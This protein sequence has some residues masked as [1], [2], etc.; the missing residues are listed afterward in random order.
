MGALACSPSS[1]LQPSSFPA[2]PVGWQRPRPLRARTPL[3]AGGRTPCPAAVLCPR[4]PLLLLPLH[5]L[6]P[7]AWQANPAARCLPRS[8]LGPLPVLCWG[9]AC[10]TPAGDLFALQPQVPIAGQTP[11]GELLGARPVAAAVLSRVPSTGP[12]PWPLVMAE[13]DGPDPGDAGRDAVGVRG[14]VPQRPGILLASRTPFGALSASRRTRPRP[15]AP[16]A[17]S[18]AWGPSPPEAGLL[19]GLPG[20]RA[21]QWPAARAAHRHLQRHAGGRWSLRWGRSLCFGIEASLCLRMLM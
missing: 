13:E 17:S 18:G 11:G 14:S 21:L 4:L 15:S 2:S 9:S 19:G 5:L 16:E 7:R 1:H 20:A 12:A 8:P 10:H 6:R 3:A